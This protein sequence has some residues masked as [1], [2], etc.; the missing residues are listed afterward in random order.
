MACKCPEGISKLRRHV[1]SCVFHVW[2]FPVWCHIYAASVR[3]QQPLPSMLQR[4]AGPDDSRLR[5]V[6]PGG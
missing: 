4:A 1:F 6:A 2:C 3:P 5:W